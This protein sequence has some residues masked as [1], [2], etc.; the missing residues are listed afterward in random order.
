MQHAA[1]P[2]V[3]LAI[4][5]FVGFALLIVAFSSGLG[6]KMTLIPEII[7]ALNISGVSAALLE[8]DRR[9]EPSPLNDTLLPINRYFGIVSSK[10]SI[11]LPTSPRDNDDNATI[12]SAICLCDTMP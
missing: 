6:V 12:S 3:F 8:N 4:Y 5:A 2:V 7:F 10:L 11:T 9:K 1:L